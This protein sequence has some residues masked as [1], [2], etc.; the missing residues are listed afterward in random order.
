M[1]F[2]K[3]Q[4]KKLIKENLRVISTI[5]CKVKKNLSGMENK[6]K[7]TE[8][9]RIRHVAVAPPNSNGM[10]LSASQV[11]PLATSSCEELL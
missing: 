10:V 7:V 3:Y 1:T 8:I 5:I 4:L 6:Y 11:P 9:I 2:K